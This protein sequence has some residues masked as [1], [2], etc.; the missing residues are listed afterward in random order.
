M[1]YTSPHAR[2]LLA[3]VSIRGLVVAC[4]IAC[5]GAALAAADQ[6]FAIM[7]SPAALAKFRN[8]DGS[9]AWCSV[10]LLG[11]HAGL[12]VGYIGRGGATFLDVERAIQRR[13][14]PM[15]VVRSREG[16]LAIEAALKRG[17]W[18]ALTWQIGNGGAP[19]R[20]CGQ[21]HGG[22]HMLNAVGIS[23]DGQQWAILDNNHL[24]RLLIVSRDRAWG[25]YN[26]GGAWGVVMEAT[27]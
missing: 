8:L 1:R 16:F 24:D 20:N 21:R 15:R 3:Q 12:N 19:C 11:I 18:V 2:S 27:R 7:P 22:L 14:L 13:G 23:A 26:A 9:C 10:G 25:E 4:V 5:L 6:G 17:E